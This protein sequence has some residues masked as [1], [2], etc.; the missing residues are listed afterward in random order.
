MPATQKLVIVVMYKKPAR[1]SF[2]F[3]QVFFLYR[4]LACNWAQLARDTNYGTWLA[5]TCI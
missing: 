1:V 2:N 5:R 4:F 3:V